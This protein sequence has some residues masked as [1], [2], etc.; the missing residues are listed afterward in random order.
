MEEQVLWSQRL[1]LTTSSEK[2]WSW[3]DLWTTCTQSSFLNQEDQAV[4]SIQYWMGYSTGWSEPDATL[5]VIPAKTLW[6]RL[7]A[8]VHG[9][10]FGPHLS[11]VK[12]Y[13]ELKKHYWLSGMLRDET[14]LT[15]ACHTCE[16]CQHGMEGDTS[17][18]S[19]PNK[20]CIWLCGRWCVIVS[21]HK[22][23]E[24]L[25]SRVRPLSDKVAGP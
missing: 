9:G 3:C 13:S 20:W 1:Y 8:K 10:C 24:P 14:A 21:L 11:D 22:E 12:V 15:R 25:H 18:H 2:S 16:T 17:S 23:R 7:M 5:W 4:C 6:E 19:N